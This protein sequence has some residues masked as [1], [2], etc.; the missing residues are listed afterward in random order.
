MVL[1]K[2]TT[3]GNFSKK[4]P[5]IVKCGREVSQQACFIEI[6]TYNKPPSGQVACPL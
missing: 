6:L 1:W 4:I 5:R 2:T 3:G